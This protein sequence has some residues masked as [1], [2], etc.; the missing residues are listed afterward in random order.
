[1]S[2]WGLALAAPALA[3]VLWAAAPSGAGAAV[4]AGPPIVAEGDFT[5][6]SA[7][8]L[9]AGLTAGVSRALRG[10]S[11][12]DGFL[13]GGAGGAV[14][15]AGRRIAVGRT[16]AA[17]LLG[18][19]VHAVGASVT[20][21]AATGAGTLASV[22]LPLGPLRVDVGR[23][24]GEGVPRLRVSGADAVMSIWA[25]SRPEL[26]LDVGE[27]VSSGALV[28]DSSE[29]IEV[30]GNR[31]QG[32]AFGGVVLLSGFLRD[33]GHALAHERVHILQHD[34]VSR[35]WTGPLEDWLLG[36]V[37]GSRHLP[38]WLQPDLLEPGLA[39]V[40]ASFGSLHSDDLPWE[41]EAR[42]L[43]ER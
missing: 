7:N 21:N 22:V 10:G 13:R 26:S 25:F 37:P 33:R 27:S 3:A 9:L 17:G 23:R 20:R 42:S 39:A 38:S 5:L 41:V 14:A 30:G 2:R 29:H 4:Q 24:P 15:Y 16:P 11:F 8:A 36:H 18:R 28:F 1:M 35:L 12:V 43:T 40:L 31:I 19:Q 6:A 34:F 32:V